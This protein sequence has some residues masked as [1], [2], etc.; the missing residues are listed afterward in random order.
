MF[1]PAERLIL[2]NKK[3]YR[4]NDFVYEAVASLEEI[5]GLP[6]A[7][8]SFRE[9][10]DV[11]LQINEQT[12]YC[13]AKK[14][15]KNANYG[16]IM[17]SLKEINHAKSNV[18]IADYLTKKTA[19]ELKENNINYL[20]ASGNAFLKANNFFIYIEGKKGKINKKTNQT[21]AFQEAG[22]KLLLLLVSN[23]ETLQ[24]SY[25]ELAEKTGIALGSVSNILKE[26]EESHYL[27]KTRNK[28]VL[29][30]QD[31][32]IERWVIAYNELLKP[33]TFK[34]KMRALG[35]EFNTNNII[36]NNMKLYCGGEPG[37]ELLTGH[38]K[39]KDY[40]I[41]TDEEISKVAKDL[42]LVPDEAG[43]IELY[44]RFWTDSLYL[45]NE[46]AAPPL[47]VYAD[48]LGTGNNRNIETAKIILENGL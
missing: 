10:Y 15:A 36:N 35:N 29:K 5:T 30:N 40:I 48:L 2:L 9:G 16:I 45:K 44:S 11:V 31:E 18:V 14:N 21:R 17:S 32:I 28:R 22:L 6:I 42:K 23:P 13:I 25:R 37:G 4:D 46:N 33:R 20:D 12:F 39:P 34:R 1:I 47:V 43:N 3:M 8:E 38:L 24:F 19:L 26:L 41:Y 7:I 27:L